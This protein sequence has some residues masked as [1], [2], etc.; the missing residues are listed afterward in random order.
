M[1]FSSV[2]AGMSISLPLSDVPLRLNV[3][4]LILRLPTVDFVTFISPVFSIFSNATSDVLLYSTVTS[5]S[6]AVR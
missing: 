6:S 5:C 3:I 1:P 4:P 2:T